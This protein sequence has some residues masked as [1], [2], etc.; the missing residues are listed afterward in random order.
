MVWVCKSVSSASGCRGCRSLCI[1]P[2]D[3]MDFVQEQTLL[4]VCD[5]SVSCEVGIS[6]NQV[7]TFTRIRNNKCSTCVPTI[8]SNS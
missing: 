3:V 6:K 4:V 2:L 8:L 5:C 1:V 7:G